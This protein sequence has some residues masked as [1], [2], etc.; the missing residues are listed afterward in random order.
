MISRKP[1]SDQPSVRSPWFWVPSLY[2][3]QGIPYVAVMI[4]SVLM[5]KR[6]GVSNTDIALYTSWLNLPWVIKPFWSPFVDLLKTKRWWVVTMQLLIGAG[7]AGVAFTI[8]TTFFFQASLAVFWLL[9][10]SS[11]THDI[12]ADGFY[13]LA[14][15]SHEQ[16]F[17]VGIRSTFYRIAIIA[18]Q[19][20]LVMFAGF[21]ENNT[22]NIPLA[23]SIT[24]FILG[25]LFLG[26]F[27]YH[28]Y[29]LPLPEGDKPSVTVTPSTIVKEFFATFVSLF[30]KET[31]F[32]RDPVHVV[33]PFS[34]S[35]VGKIGNPFPG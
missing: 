10:F 30:Q 21:L 25:G 6:L 11:A 2:F 34:G 28:R 24:F 33:V 19:G 13:M 7:L 32:C 35:P 12:A 27:L 15:D 14:L 1:L 16:A 31:S 26:L 4:V 29:I 5:Y 8:P 22:G 20:V 3:A 18:G 9:A 23:W 17:F